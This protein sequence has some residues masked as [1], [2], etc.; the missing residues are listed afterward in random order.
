MFVLVAG[1]GALL[2]EGLITLVTVEHPRDLLHLLPPAPPLA[3]RHLLVRLQAHQFL[4]DH[5][6]KVLLR[7]ATVAVG[8]VEADALLLLLLLPF[9]HYERRRGGAGAEVL[10]GQVE[11][12]AVGELAHPGHEGERGAGGT[13]ALPAG[14]A[15]RG[16]GV[17]GL[18]GGEGGQ[19]ALPPVSRSA[20]L[21]PDFD[22]LVGMAD[23]LGDL[24][25][26]LPP[27][28]LVDAVAALEDGQLLLR[29]ERP[30]PALLLAPGLLLLAALVLRD[31]AVAVVAVVTGHGAGPGGRRQHRGPAQHVLL[32]E[33]L[34]DGHVDLLEEE[35]EVVLAAAQEGL[36]DG[37]GM[38]Q[39]RV[40]GRQV[41]LSLLH[42]LV[43]AGDGG[44]ED[45]GV[46]DTHGAG[47]E[48]GPGGRG[49]AARRLLRLLLLGY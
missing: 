48:E 22:D 26:L 29:D 3:P 20:V 25:Q 18:G 24:K 30:H 10:G 4:P 2:G 16:R 5:R 1:N 49:R 40:E 37:G 44:G 31:V 43:H 27:G 9:L 41:G 35:A 36:G 39:A 45:V 15:G 17:L 13:A 11:G 33:A 12:E 23:G 38:G 32:Q 21:E 19:L 8:R 42:Q 6:L 34:G 14:R 47:E 28:H 7:H 46:E